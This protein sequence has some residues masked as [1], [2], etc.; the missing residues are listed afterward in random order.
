[1]SQVLQG[2]VR[3]GKIEL[4]DGPELAEGQHVRVLIESDQVQPADA[5][6]LREEGVVY[7]PPPPALEALLDQIRHTRAPLGPS[8]TGPGRKSVAGALANDPTWDEQLRELMESRKSGA[9]RER[10]G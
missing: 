3:G 1:M 4:I 5:E 8:P 6:L 7:T 9:Y 10:R 2:V